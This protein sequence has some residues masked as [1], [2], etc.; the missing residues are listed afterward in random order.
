MFNKAIFIPKV[1]PDETVRVKITKD[2][3]DYYFGELVE[4]IKPSKD[5]IDVPCQYFSR[6]GGCDYQHIKYQ[7]QLSF[8]ENIFIETI[9]RV[10]GLNE[11]PIKPIIPSPEPFHYRI[12]TQLKTLRTGEKI[13]LGYFKKDSHIFVPIGECII[14]HKKI[15]ELMKVLNELI[16][17]NLLYDLD[18][19][20]VIL[21][22]LTDKLL[23]LLSENKAHKNRL[24]SLYSV[25]KKSNRGIA[26]VLSRR[27]RKIDC[28]GKSFVEQKINNINYRVSSESFFQVNYLLHETLVNEILNLVSPGKKDNIFDIYS[29]VGMFSLPI[30]LKANFVYGIDE[31][32]SSIR[33]AVYNQKSNKIKNCEFVNA[34]AEDGLILL[35]NKK[36]HCDTAL[37]NPPR[38][39]CSEKVKKH[40]VGFNP[41][42]IIYLSCNPSTLARDLSSFASGGY[43]IRSIQPIDQFPQTYHIEALV[44]L[45]KN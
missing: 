18:E 32:A 10:G 42:N 33:D 1:I 16:N 37:L 27:K 4:I 17:Q 12:K 5:R 34:K 20:D 45:E 35:K 44:K 31:S 11:I 25:I 29:G 15:N 21:S 23:L 3:G 24:Q 13:S 28:V 9:K 30:A 14:C 2:K 36:V 41:L 26:G 6:C 38:S 19:F 39:G 43:A 7:S 22:N 40:I 8:K